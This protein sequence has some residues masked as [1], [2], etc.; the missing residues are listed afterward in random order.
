MLST[1]AN[2]NLMIHSLMMLLWDETEKRNYFKTLILLY[3]YKNPLQ[4][5][6][7]Y[8]LSYKR[9]QRKKESQRHQLSLRWYV[10][11]KRL[12]FFLPGPKTLF[13]VLGV[14]TYDSLQEH[15]TNSLPLEYHRWTPSSI[16][17]SNFQMLRLLS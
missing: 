17:F 11:I 5:N 7:I 14:L 8:I 2:R 9:K 16:L 1:L 13:L 12:S 15:S 6:R 4:A 10:Y 3:I